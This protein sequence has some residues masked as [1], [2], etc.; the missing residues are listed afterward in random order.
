M[1]DG[2]TGGPGF[3]CGPPALH[4]L[5][6]FMF[7]KGYQVLYLDQRGTGLSTLISPATL[8]RDHASSKQRTVQ[9]QAQYLKHF[10]ADNI[11]MY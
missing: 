10:R 2:L 5:T 9:E 3:G 1:T 4:P 8:A 7:E 6:N 11:G